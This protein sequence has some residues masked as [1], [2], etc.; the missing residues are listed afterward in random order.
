MLKIIFSVLCVT[1]VTAQYDEVCFDEPD[2]YWPHETD[3]GMYIFCT[4]DN[5]LVDGVCPPETPVFDTEWLTC[6]RNKS[7]KKKVKMFKD[8]YY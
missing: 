4:E 6:G 2:R 8:Q 7:F 3:C 5:I 1:A